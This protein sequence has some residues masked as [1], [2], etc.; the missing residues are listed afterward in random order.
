LE[1]L[2]DFPKNGEVITPLG[3]PRLTVLKALFTFANT[4][5]LEALFLLCPMRN[6]FEIVKLTP[7][8]L[9]PIRLRRRMPGG[10]HAP[11]EL[12]P[13]QV[14]PVGRE[15]IAVR[16][17]AERAIPRVVAQVALIRIA[18]LALMLKML[19]R[20]NALHSWWVISS[21]GSPRDAVARRL[22]A[23]ERLE[24]RELKISEEVVF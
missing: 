5:R 24:A 8:Y 22:A 1:A 6:A 18:E 10:V 20:W 4:L 3:V 16:R 17:I 13:G 15:V 9:G 14:G 23:F 7:R 21:R 19:N 12:M 2:V 11:V